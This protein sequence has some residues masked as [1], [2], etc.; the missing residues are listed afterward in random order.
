MWIIE[1]CRAFTGDMRSSHIRQ[2]GSGAI[3][4]KYMVHLTSGTDEDVIITSLTNFKQLESWGQLAS[5]IPTFICYLRVFCCLDNTYTHLVI[6]N[7]A[8]AQPSA[9]LRNLIG[10]FTVSWFII[11]LRPIRSARSTEHLNTSCVINVKRIGWS[12]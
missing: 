2:L 11:K 4:I 8:V 9:V 12:E 5:V 6:A 10:P 3:L 7:S 1:Y